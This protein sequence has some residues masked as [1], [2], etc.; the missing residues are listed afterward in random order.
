MAFNCDSCGVKDSEVK[1]GAGIEPKGRKI[2]LRM[3]DAAMDLN[4]D[5]LKVRQ[6]IVKRAFVLV[7]L[8]LWST[9][10]CWKIGRFV[11]TSDGP[12]LVTKDRHCS[13]SSH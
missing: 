11:S 12:D 2:T 8:A 4:R 6:S 5:V 1:S 10:L 3:T 9:R 13:K 7:S